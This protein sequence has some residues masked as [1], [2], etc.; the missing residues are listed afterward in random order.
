MLLLIPLLPLVGFVVNA[1]LGRRLPK[2]ISG[3][4]RVRR[5]DR[6]VRRVGLARLARAR[7]ARRAARV[8]RSSTWIASGDLQRAVRAAARSSLGR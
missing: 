2:S 3:G 6:V 7:P 4:A 5:D 1:A 8:R